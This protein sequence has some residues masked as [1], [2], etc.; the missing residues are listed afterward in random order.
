MGRHRH[1]SRPVRGARIRALLAG[2]LALGI[3]ATATLAS[4]TDTEKAQGAF[5]TSVFNTESSIDNGVSYADNNSGS[6]ATLSFPA[7]G[8]SPN[9]VRYASMLV[10]TKAGSI[11]GTMTLSGGTYS[12][13]GSDE[14]TVLGAALRY[15][16]VST[17]ATCN[18]AAFSGSPTW[19][20]GPTAQ[21]LSTAGSVAVAL[22][23]AGVS[24]PGTASGLCFEV[25]LPSTA[26][27]GLQGRN[28]T[29][30]WQIVATSS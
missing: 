17:T 18:A 11:T 20:V 26:D 25:S 28:S 21:P 29:A 5:T 15:R 12:P 27:T 30:Q 4:W 19:V 14:T 22:A 13:A 10:R 7:S 2:A 6:G 1:A 9:T 3:G 24:T 23:A 8:M 16:V